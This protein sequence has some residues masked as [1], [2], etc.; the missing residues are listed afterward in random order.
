MQEYNF[1]IVSIDE[2][3]NIITHDYHTKEQECTPFFLSA[4]EC[5]TFLKLRTEQEYTHDARA[6]IK[7][8]MDL[9]NYEMFFNGHYKRLNLL[10]NNKDDMTKIKMCEVLQYSPF[11]NEE[12]TDYNYYIEKMLCHNIILNYNSS[13]KNIIDYK[14]DKELSTTDIIVNI[15]RLL[16]ET[17][18]MNLEETIVKMLNAKEIEENHKEKK[19]YRYNNFNI[20]LF[21]ECMNEEDCK[22]YFEVMVSKYFKDYEPLWFK[23]LYS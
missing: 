19:I 5:L 20:A 4:L 12:E 6:N 18:N 14:F 7:Y 8:P 21:Q 23:S 16:K 3:L 15:D 9:E 11:K 22:E 1:R 10:F 2:D 17:S 13:S